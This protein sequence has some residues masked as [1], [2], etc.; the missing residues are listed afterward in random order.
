MRRDDLRI[1]AILLAA[2]QGTRF[3][4][5]PK[6]LASL[7]GRPLV[8]HAAEAVLASVARPML[9]V[10]GHEAG[11]V[12]A[13]LAGLEGI[14]V[15]NPDHRDGLST[16][17]RAGFS[18]L[19]AETD[20]VVVCLGDMPGVT[21]ALIDRLCAAFTGEEAAVVPVTGGRR[22]NPVLLNPRRLGPEIE[23]LRGDR[24]AGALLRGR[25][26]VREV[27]LDDPGLLDD[28]DTPEALASFVLRG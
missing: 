20:G 14:P 22:G 24:G 18:A 25:A 11:P 26:D 23:T 13:A 2:G 3:G 6:L 21:A 1:A 9:I 12:R 28:V 7:R 17:L 15:L 5:A 16:S 8:R 10:L 4:A 27:L 19:P